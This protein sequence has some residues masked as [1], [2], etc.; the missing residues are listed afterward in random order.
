MMLPVQQKHFQI[1]LNPSTNTQIQIWGFEHFH[2]RINSKILSNIIRSPKVNIK[3]I[4]V[5]LRLF[6]HLYHVP[7]SYIFQPYS[8]ILNSNGN[9]VIWVNGPNVNS[10]NPFKLIPFTKNKWIILKLS[11]LWY[12]CLVSWTHSLYLVSNLKSH[13]PMSSHNP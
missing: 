11:I 9:W 13:P 10:I 6:I 4:S 2:H 12:F 5:N 3:I 7:R 1:N 8:P